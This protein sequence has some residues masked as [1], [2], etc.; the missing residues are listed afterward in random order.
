M[1]FFI[2]QT[3]W[4]LIKVWA[5]ILEPFI[6]IWDKNVGWGHDI[7]HNDNRHNDSQPGS[8][9]L[10]FKKYMHLIRILWLVTFCWGS[11][12]SK[13]L[14]RM[15]LCLVSFCWMSCRHTECHT[16]LP[17]CWVLFHCSVECCSYHIGYFSTSLMKLGS[18][19]WVHKTRIHPL[20]HG[21][22]LVPKLPK[23]LY[24]QSGSTPFI[25]PNPVT[26]IQIEALFVLYK[27]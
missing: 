21:I 12:C 11:S 6:D 26:L 24:L 20:K 2:V 27:H 19:N 18:N 1:M 7:H 13:T 23:L 8:K 3:T 16:D 4:I 22:T 5:T 14:R 10:H 9:K 17:L 25:F 15:S